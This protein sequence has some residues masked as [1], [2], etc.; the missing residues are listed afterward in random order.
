MLKFPKLNFVYKGEEAK[1]FLK[2]KNDGLELIREYFH[3]PVTMP[4]DILRI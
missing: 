1:N 4:E 2:T 3:D